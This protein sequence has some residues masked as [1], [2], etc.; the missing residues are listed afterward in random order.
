[1][2]TFFAVLAL[3]ASYLSYAGLKWALAKNNIDEN[4]GSLCFCFSWLL[5]PAALT[6]WLGLIDTIT[7]RTGTT[8]II[9]WL[10]RSF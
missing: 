3:S 8:W 9:D 4:F 7:Q 1:M 6:G 2:I 10:M 5:I